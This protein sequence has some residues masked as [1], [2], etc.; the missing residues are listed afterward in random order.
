M[1]A[2]RI[3]VALTTTM[4][5]CCC[6]AEKRLSANYVFLQYVVSSPHNSDTGDPYFFDGE[7]ARIECKVG[8]TVMVF[9]SEVSFCLL[10]FHLI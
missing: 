4:F 7:M 2:Q 5:C 3:Q 8:F 6:F 1:Q 9:G 10:W